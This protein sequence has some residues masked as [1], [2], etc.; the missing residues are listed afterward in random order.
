M[1][2]LFLRQ[3]RIFCVGY[4][5]IFIFFSGSTLTRLYCSRTFCKN[6]MHIFL[7]SLA[8]QNHLKF[9]GVKLYSGVIMPS[10]IRKPI[11]HTYR[12][13]VTIFYDRK[14]SR[15]FFPTISISPVPRQ[16]T[17]IIKNKTYISF[18]VVFL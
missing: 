16:L 17:Q 18:R 14:T 10:V 2:K 9:S 8:N 5:V 3:A 4:R 11:S 13:F 15:N 1:I 6:Q 12:F 7:E